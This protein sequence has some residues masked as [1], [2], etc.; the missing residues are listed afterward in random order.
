MKELWAQCRER[1]AADS[2]DFLFDGLLR[3]AGGRA[4]HDDIAA[5]VLKVLA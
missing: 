4:P 3:F 5:I 1:S 2:M